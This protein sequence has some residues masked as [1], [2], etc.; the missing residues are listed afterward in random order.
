MDPNLTYKVHRTEKFQLPFF[1]VD[2][3]HLRKRLF[4]S[5]ETTLAIWHEEVILWSLRRER[6]RIFFW[7]R[8]RKFHKYLAGFQRLRRVS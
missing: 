7:K 2:T 3:N 6:K 4:Q 8:I 5:S 1:K